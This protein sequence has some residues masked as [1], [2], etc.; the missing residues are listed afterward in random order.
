MKSFK[1]GV[2]RFFPIRI[3]LTSTFALPLGIDA[4]LS[5]VE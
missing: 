5:V 3:S 2:D 1:T 4:V